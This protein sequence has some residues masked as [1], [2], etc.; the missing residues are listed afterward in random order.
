MAKFRVPV[1]AVVPGYVDVEAPTA[2]EAT[3]AATAT[4]AAVHCDVERAQVI[5]AVGAA[6][7]IKEPADA[8]P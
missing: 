8:T 5:A 3:C 4:T 7:E 2:W 1:R 6:I